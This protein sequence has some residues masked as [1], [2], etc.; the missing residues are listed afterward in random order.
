M[1]VQDGS[2]WSI[3]A[4]QYD[5]L[6]NAVGG[7]IPVNTTTANLQY[8]PTVAALSDGGYVVTWMSYLQDGSDWG[9]YSRVF[10]VTDVAEN[11]SGDDYAASTATTGVV[12]V[13]GSTTGTIET[14]G[15]QD[16]FAVTLTAGETYQFK[17][18][19]WS[20]GQG[21][22]LQP[23][24]RLLDHNG[25]SVNGLGGFYQGT[26]GV[27]YTATSTATY[28]LDIVSSG[29]PN[30][31][32]T[33]KVS[34]TP[35]NDAP[36]AVD[37]S[38]ITNE[39]TTLTVAAAGVLGN[40]TDAD[41]DPLS[42]ILVSGPAHGTLAF[43]PDGAFSYTPLANYFGPDSFTYKLNDGQADSNVATVSLTV[44]P[45]N[46]APVAVN[47]IAGVAKGRAITA[48]AQHG[49]LVND[50]DLDGDGLSVSAVNGSAANVG[51]AVA[52]TFGLLT[53]NTDGSYDY[54]AN[55]GNLLPHIVAQDSF[56]Y[57]ASDGHG[58]IS[59]ATLTVT[60]TNRGAVYL[61]GTDGNNMLTAGNG[62][63]VLDGGNG[64]DTLKGGINADAL[65]GGHGNDTMT[66]GGGSDTFVFA[67]NFG[68]DLMT[69]FKPNI[70]NIQFDHSLF[71][72][73]ADVQT[74]ATSDPDGNT[75]IAYDATTRSPCRVWR[76]QAC[77]RMTFSSS[78]DR[79]SS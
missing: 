30:D 18:E 20:T 4:Q 40:D 74:H 47:D 37:D 57:T 77:T 32:G 15:D 16:W 8:Q 31:F 60:I 38:Y 78:E 22:L 62:P 9:V 66:G 52:G 69:D 21:T 67:A 64:N 70:D 48:D 12:A 6:G 39:D 29:G 13:N 19:G 35:V 61:R 2:G 27:T 46:D 14:T 65:I 7:E 42:A 41:G 3:Y 34:V 11:T 63:T 72:N 33:Y 1:S 53:L 56:I 54:V 68:E 5:H 75:V 43:N 25:N 71:A 49:V 44:S 79:R 50:S 73:F 10:T 45:V 55:Q 24:L 59:T 26:E 17:A 23:Y 28:Y 76:S 58:G 36:V 51:Q